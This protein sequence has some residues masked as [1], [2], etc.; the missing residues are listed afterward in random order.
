MKLAYAAQLSSATSPS[1]KLSKSAAFW[2][3]MLRSSERAAHCE[4]WHSYAVEVEAC[5]PR[6][7]LTMSGTQCHRDVAGRLTLGSIIQS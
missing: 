5:I 3:Q 4:W 1:T 6:D 7:F 2:D